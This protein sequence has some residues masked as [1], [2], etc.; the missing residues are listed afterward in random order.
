MNLLSMFLPRAKESRPHRLQSS[1]IYR[2]CAI[3]IDLG[4]CRRQLLLTCTVIL[5]NVLGR[6][7]G[8]TKGGGLPRVFLESVSLRLGANERPLLRR[9]SVRSRGGGLIPRESRRLILTLSRVPMCPHRLINMYAHP[10]HILIACRAI[11]SIR[12]VRGRIQVSLV[13]RLCV[14]VLYGIHLLP[15]PLRLPSN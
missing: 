12:Q 2:P 4:L 11:R 14:S 5:Y 6:R 7:L 8:Q 15:L 1:I 3:L 10:L 13:L 9:V